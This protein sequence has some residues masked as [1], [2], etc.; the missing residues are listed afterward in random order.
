MPVELQTLL[1]FV[2]IAL[3]LNF[4]PGADMLFCLGQGVRS[5]PRAG[6]AASL[7]IATGSFLHSVAAGL[8]LASLIAA[9]P[10]AFEVIRWSGVA[11]LLWLAIG[12]LRQPMGELQP[13]GVS[14]ASVY[15]A[16]A[17]G[18]LVCLLNP[19]VALFILA[20]VPQFVDPSQGSVFLQFLIFGA[21]L[22]IGGTLVNGLVGGFSGGIGRLLAQ[23]R[24]VARVL[25]YVTSFVFCILAAKLAF[26]R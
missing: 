5:G 24:L 18:T 26:D 11:Y 10:L 19:K 3:S 16:W 20:L 7:G 6:V 4:T 21:I 15:N 1:I 14:R 25:Q 22:N 8:G 12:V 13:A 23:N 9:H 2:P 17:N